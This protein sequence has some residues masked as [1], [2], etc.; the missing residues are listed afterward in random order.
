M[1]K[2]HYEMIRVKDLIVHQRVKV[3][4]QIFTTPCQQIRCKHVQLFVQTD[5]TQ[6]FIP[7]VFHKFTLALIVTLLASLPNCAV[8]QEEDFAAVACDNRIM[9]H[10]HNGFAA[11]LVDPCKTVHNIAC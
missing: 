10:Y 1:R 9:R 2:L 4:K 8:C 11:V 7:D 5:L 3:H 6:H